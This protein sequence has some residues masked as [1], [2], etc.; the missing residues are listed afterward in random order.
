M[1]RVRVDKKIK[2]KNKP[3]NT[4]HLWKQAAMNNR[5]SA[6]SFASILSSNLS[7]KYAV[8]ILRTRLG[9]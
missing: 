1:T 2:N 6:L 7:A 9:L 8:W 4:D 5:V 3:G